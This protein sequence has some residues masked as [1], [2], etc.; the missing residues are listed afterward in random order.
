MPPHLVLI[1][2]NP[3]S[4]EL[5]ARYTSHFATAVLIHQPAMILAIS[6]RHT[7]RGHKP[8]NS[9]VGVL[10][11]LS[12]KSSHSWVRTHS[13]VLNTRTRATMED[14]V[15]SKARFPITTTRISI[16]PRG[17][18]RMPRVCM[19]LVIPCPCRPM[20]SYTFKPTSHHHP[21]T[22]HQ[23]GTLLTAIHSVV[24]NPQRGVP[25]RERRLFTSS[26]MRHLTMG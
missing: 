12:V 5:L 19:W 22:L 13:A 6:R 3:T 16:F 11:C 26:L 24:M 1:I 8:R 10:V 18:I 21:A 9:L 17:R 25:S 4:T 14:G 7:L 20:L 2:T 23:I 15:H